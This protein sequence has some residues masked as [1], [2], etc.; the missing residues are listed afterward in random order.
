MS[1]LT[2]RRFLQA[3]LAAAPLVALTPTVPLFVARSALAA[4][5]TSDGRILVVVELVGGNDGINTVV[6]F[7]DE[8]Y[9]KHRRSL[10]LPREQ[11]IR[12]SDEVGLHPALKP[13]A[14]VWEDGRLAIAQGVS[15]PNPS[16]SHFVSREVWHTA[17]RDTGREQGVGWLGR[18]LDGAGEQLAPAVYVGDGTV[19]P[20]SLRGRL[21]SCVSVGRL[22]D[23]R[24]AA[25][26]PRGGPAA[27]VPSGEPQGDDLLAYARRA[28]LDAAQTADLFADPKLT[29]G[30][31]QYPATPLGGRL[32]VL[33]RAIKAG[34]KA[35]IYYVTQGSGD[36]GEGNYDTHSGQL[37]IHAGLLAELATGWAAL[38]ADLQASRLEDRVALL[39]FSEFGR[40]VEENASGGTDHGTA[41][42]V[43]LAGGGVRG[44]LIGA[45]PRLLDLEDGDLKRSLDFR[46]VY[47]TL[48]EK[49]LGI[50][51]EVALGGTFESLP[52]FR[53]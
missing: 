41:A 43:P 47:A 2:R 28:A 39:A 53:L 13:L 6:P 44:G 8:G 40:R 22:E 34:L 46:R 33:A 10:R 18:G 27:L 37:P 23:C 50:S 29:S 14:R 49:W 7:A 17:R 16:R 9:A 25:E 30:G 48:L 15:Y 35:S 21:R 11:L 12:I 52:L 5:K 31:P 36:V 3:S 4:Q 51:A 26:L 45:T 20:V 1:E 24:L 32:Q 42:P 38:L 19:I